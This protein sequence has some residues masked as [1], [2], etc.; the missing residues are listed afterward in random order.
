M[1]P[2][3]GIRADAIGGISKLVGRVHA[4]TWE[5]KTRRNGEIMG[6]RPGSAWDSLNTHTSNLSSLSPFRIC[7][8]W[9]P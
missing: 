9:L 7:L 5:V 3:D 1:G 2:K 4:H 6:E 8:I